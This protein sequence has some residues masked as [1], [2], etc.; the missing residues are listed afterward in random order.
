MTSGAV[1]VTYDSVDDKIYWG[2]GK[3]IY[4]GNRNGMD[5]ETVLHIDEC[6]LIVSGTGETFLN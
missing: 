2:L 5:V 3:D 6:K 4:R 1:G